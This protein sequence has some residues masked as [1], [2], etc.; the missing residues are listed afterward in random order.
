MYWVISSLC[1]YSFL[2]SFMDF[3]S[4]FCWVRL[5][6]S[7]FGS[8]FFSFSFLHFLPLSFQPLLELQLSFPGGASGK[9]P[10][11]QFKR[12]KGT[13]FHLWVG[14]IPWKRKWQPAGV[15]LLENLMDRG[16]WWATVHGVTNSQ[17][18]LMWQH[19]A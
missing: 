17:T 6:L 1:G 13:K 15:L 18:W 11:C 8:H 5:V 19:I 7:N 4:S 10:A 14:K 12:H 16:A 9:E 2:S 3:F